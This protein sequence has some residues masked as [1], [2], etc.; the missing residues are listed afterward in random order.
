MEEFTSNKTSNICKAFRELSVQFKKIEQ[1][2]RSLIYVN[3]YQE[4]SPIKTDH[5]RILNTHSQEFISDYERNN[6]GHLIKL[7]SG[8]NGGITIS[9]M[10]RINEE[11][12]CANFL[13]NNNSEINNN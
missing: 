9:E 4:T 6:L 2:F 3:T 13:V 8:H 12:S 10:E 1:A 7:S 11:L 5:L